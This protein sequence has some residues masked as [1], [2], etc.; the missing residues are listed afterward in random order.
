MKRIITI[1]PTSNKIRNVLSWLIIPAR[2]QAPS[3]PCR[4]QSTTLCSRCAC[5]SR[6]DASNSMARC[7]RCSSTRPSTR[8][9]GV[10]AWAFSSV[11]ASLTHRVRV[12]APSTMPW[13]L[14]RQ[15][16]TSAS[17]LGFT[18]GLVFSVALVIIIIFIVVSYFNK[19]IYPNKSWY[20]LFLRNHKAA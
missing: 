12:C 11:T 4:A 16:G 3:V 8:A 9:R 18:W 10:C 6:R 15:P 7:R 2:Q 5:G 17:I 19:I 14:C 13:P 1:T 20:F